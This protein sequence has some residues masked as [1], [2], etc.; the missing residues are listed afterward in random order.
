MW[1]IDA[2]RV[3]FVVGDD[4]EPL[5]DYKTGDPV[6]TKDGLRLWRVQ[7]VAFIEGQGTELIQVKVPG[8]PKGLKKQ[9]PA[10][11][12]HLAMKAWAN[13][14]GNGTTYNAAAVLPEGVRSS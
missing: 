10:L 7:I 2:T 1:P 11:I 8:E 4:P 9:S 6:V 5:S 14:R 3:K 12:T 13:E